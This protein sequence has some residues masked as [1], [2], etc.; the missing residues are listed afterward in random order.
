MQWLKNNGILDSTLIKRFE[1][2][3]IRFGKEGGAKFHSASLSPNGPRT[4]SDRPSGSEI[5]PETDNQPADSQT[6][7]A[8][9]LEGTNARDME[10]SQKPRSEVK[11]S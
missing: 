6:Q 10:L 5:H 7:S 2:V 8:P 11:P 9:Q 3:R 4:P 1:N